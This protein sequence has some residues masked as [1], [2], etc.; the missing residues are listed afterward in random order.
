MRKNDTIRRASAEAIAAMRL[1]GELRSDWKAA[2]AMSTAEVERLADAEDGK[3]PE[4]WASTAELGIPPR[5]EP[6]H[7]RLDAEVLAWFRAQG[8]GYQTR[9]NAVLRSFVRTRL[10]TIV[11]ER[12]QR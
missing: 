1:A 9:I 6:V 12:Q 8:P 11:K 3:L 7:I 5:K 10:G 2:A 4:G